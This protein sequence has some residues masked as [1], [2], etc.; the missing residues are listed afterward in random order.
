MG[1]VPQHPYHTRTNNYN[2]K[3]GWVKS[4]Y[5]LT[6]PFSIQEKWSPQRWRSAVPAVSTDRSSAAIPVPVTK[7]GADLR[8]QSVGD[9]HSMPEEVMANARTMF[10]QKNLPL[11]LMYV[12][13]TNQCPM[14]EYCVGVVS[15][16]FSNTHSYLQS[17]WI[18]ATG[19]WSSRCGFTCFNLCSTPEQIIIYFNL[20]ID[21]HVD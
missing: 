10:A 2:F 7:N 11:K 8:L 13:N 3:R 9:R 21:K 1:C 12:L 4:R 6:A 18:V 5:G 14:P 16:G 20:K 17:G 19:R 15:P